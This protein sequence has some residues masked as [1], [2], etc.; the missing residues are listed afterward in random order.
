MT[1]EPLNRAP[2]GLKTAGKR[3]WRAITADLEARGLALSPSQAAVL[4]AACRQADVVARLEQEAAEMPTVVLGSTRQPVVNPVIAEAR[5][6]RALFGQLL[7]R[8]DADKE[9]ETAEM[10]PAQ[11][12]AQRAA[13]SRWR[14]D[15][16][17][18][19]GV[20]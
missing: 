2:N 1:S 12:R 3:L 7:S 20:S 13:Q 11:L 6:G 16:E 4:E 9:P 14:Q 5:Q 15:A 18:R 19:R 10:T 17:R 8:L